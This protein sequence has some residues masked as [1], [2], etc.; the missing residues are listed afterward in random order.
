[1]PIRKIGIAAGHEHDIAFQRAVLD[2][3]RAVHARMETIIFAQK[4]ENRSFRE[5]L[6][7]R[8][9]HH[10]SILIK[11]VNGLVPIEGI[12]LNTERGVRKLRTIHDGLN[13]IRQ[14]TRFLR[15]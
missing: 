2:C 1:M 6:G 11:P 15:K 14:S 5:Q 4:L 10:Q 3:A 9:R 12:E 7:R 8:A 13:A